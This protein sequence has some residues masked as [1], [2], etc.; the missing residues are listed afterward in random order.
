[1][2]GNPMTAHDMTGFGV[3]FSRKV[4]KLMDTAGLD[5]TAHTFWKL[6]E[7]KGNNMF[8]RVFT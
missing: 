2:T 7:I 3:P 8:L 4:R 6:M 1:M 5:G